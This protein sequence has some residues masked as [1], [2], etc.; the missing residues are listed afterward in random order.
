MTYRLTVIIFHSGSATLLV[1]PSYGDGL[2]RDVVHV[3]GKLLKVY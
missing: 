2:P 1:I 3:A